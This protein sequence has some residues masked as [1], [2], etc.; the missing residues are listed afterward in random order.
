M[1]W[2]RNILPRDGAGHWPYPCG[3][4]SVRG[5]VCVLPDRHGRMHKDAVEYKWAAA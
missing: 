1:K 4:T 3:Q 2:L 5:R